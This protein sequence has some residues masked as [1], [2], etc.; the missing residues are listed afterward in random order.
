MWAGVAEA[1]VRRA[2]MDGA[3]IERGKAEVERLAE[4]VGRLRTEVADL[5]NVQTETQEVGKS[6]SPL[7]PELV[8]GGTV[9]ANTY[10]LCLH[11]HSGR[12]VAWSDHNH[13]DRIGF[14]E[15]FDADKL[16]AEFPEGS[17]AV[18][19]LFRLAHIVRKALSESNDRACWRDVFNPEVAAMFGLP[20]PMTLLPKSCF[21]GNCGA[22]YD[23][24]A[25]GTRY[26]TPPI[27]GEQFAEFI[28]P[29]LDQL[30]DYNRKHFFDE[31]KDGYC[32][33]CG[34]KGRCRCWDDE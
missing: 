34:C 15:D 4:E 17:S 9:N 5:V 25:A 20:W 13:D 28:K 3:E 19:T 29:W 21:L 10:G 1:A 33:N 7:L 32:V 22:F 8:I 31:I 27:D 24:L 12:I 26:E 2:A 30:S 11:D 16:E 6:D 14:V 18:I 23:T